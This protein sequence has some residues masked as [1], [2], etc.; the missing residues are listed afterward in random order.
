MRRD[1]R[2]QRRLRL[3]AQ[4][5]GYTVEFLRWTPPRS[6]RPMQTEIDDDEDAIAVGTWVIDGGWEVEVIAPDGTEERLDDIEA[7]MV[8]ERI[9]RLPVV[10]MMGGVA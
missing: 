9:E 10:T 7:W 2:A 6:P 4:A 1:S 5:R 3:A 8:M